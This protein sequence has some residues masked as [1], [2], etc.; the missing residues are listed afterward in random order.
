MTTRRAFLA[1][2]LRVNLGVIAGLSFLQANR[3]EARWI[4][5]QARLLRPLEPIVW[6]EVSGSRLRITV[7][8]RMTATA[9]KTLATAEAHVPSSNATARANKIGILAHLRAVVTEA[10][11]KSDVIIRHVHGVTFLAP[12]SYARAHATV[13]VHGLNHQGIKVDKVWLS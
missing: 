12:D 5:S 9:L 13:L 3:V 11:S 1:Q 6:I 2:L 7:A 10:E 8:E 4:I